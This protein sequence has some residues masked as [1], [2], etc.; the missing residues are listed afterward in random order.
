MSRAGYG[1]LALLLCA[2]CSEQ[3]PPGAADGTYTVSCQE[4]IPEFRLSAPESPSA[5]EIE[6]LCRCIWEL[7]GDWERNTAIAYVEGR[8][9]GHVAAVQK[10]LQT[11]NV[12]M[13]S[14]RN[15]SRVRLE[16]DAPAEG[17]DR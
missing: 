14:S 5:A 3:A 7:M 17:S 1:C 15:P 11:G 13:A 10:D 12:L 6:A 8:D 16:H 2:A 4:P 9:A